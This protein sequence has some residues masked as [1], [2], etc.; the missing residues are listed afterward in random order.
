M[1]LHVFLIEYSSLRDSFE[2]LEGIDGRFRATHLLHPS[3]AS[4]K[5][6]SFHSNPRLK[7]D[8]KGMQRDSWPRTRLRAAVTSV[9]RIVMDTIVA[10]H[11]PLATPPGLNNAFRWRFTQTITREYI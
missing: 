6:G 5:G 9:V 10:Q 8:G 1:R 4:L 2:T 11:P 3:G 7:W